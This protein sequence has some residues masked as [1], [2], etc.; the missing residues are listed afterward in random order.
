MQGVLLN[1]GTIAAGNSPGLLSM[2][3]LNGSNGTFAFELGA[4]TTRGVTYDAMDVSGLLTLGNS[5]AWTFSVLDNYA[6]QDADAY[7]L[8]NFDSI[9]AA[10]FDSAVLLAALPTLSDGLQ[11]NVSSFTTDGIVN[12]IPEPSASLLFAIGVTGLIGTRMYNRRK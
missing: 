6:F 7:D 5:T 8:F 1:G 2:T 12:V 4:P 9:D 11:W 3:S 10:A